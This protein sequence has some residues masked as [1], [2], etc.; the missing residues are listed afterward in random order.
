M[1][2]VY[3]VPSAHDE[4]NRLEPSPVETDQILLLAREIAGHK[5]AGFP[6]PFS[7]PP[8]EWFDI[9]NIRMVY[10]IRGEVMEILKFLRV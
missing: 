3:V 10:R 2:R 5:N 4:L 7:H 6:V 9:G 8:A 1:L